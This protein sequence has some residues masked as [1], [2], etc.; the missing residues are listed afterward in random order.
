[1]PCARTENG[2]RFLS[3]LLEYNPARR[4]TALVGLN[5][6]YFAEKPV[7]GSNSFISPGQKKPWFQYPQRKM[8][9]EKKSKK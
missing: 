8:Q 6:E 7:P 5:H 9:D 2:F 4:L 1:M 3:S